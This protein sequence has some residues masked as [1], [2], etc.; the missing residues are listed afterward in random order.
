MRIDEW[1]SE[2][3]PSTRQWLIDNAG[4]VVPAWVLEQIT[5]VTGE[6]T[7]DDDWAADVDAEEFYL[8]DDA[9][10][11]IEAAGN[12]EL[13]DLDESELVTDDEEAAGTSAS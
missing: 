10:D 6:P 12:D 7:A 4:D 9:T 2:L 11:W 1:W 3:V 13:D 8:S 5:A